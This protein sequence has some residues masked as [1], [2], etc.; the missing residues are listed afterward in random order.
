M[1]G[2][3]S[4]KFLFLSLWDRGQSRCIVN[5][6]KVKAGSSSWFKFCE[7]YCIWTGRKEQ[8]TQNTKTI[9][10]GFTFILDSL[11]SGARDGFFLCRW[12]IERDCQER[13]GQR[14]WRQKV[15]SEARV[16][17]PLTHKGMSLALGLISPWAL[18]HELHKSNSHLESRNSPFLPAPNAIGWN[19]W[20]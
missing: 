16:T 9:R 2:G 10:T 13:C 15:K 7:N 12:F 11:G 17:L 5:L 4:L 19:H 14:K 20:L 3:Y 8:V 18:E 1:D 6:A